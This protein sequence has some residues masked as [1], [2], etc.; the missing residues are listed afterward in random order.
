MAE[1]AL[2]AR[3]PSL[4]E[5]LA[6][7]IVRALMRRDGVTEQGIVTVLSRAKLRLL[8]AGLAPRGARLA[9]PAPGRPGP[10]QWRL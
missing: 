8:D 6:E 7:P 10:E 1:P 4:G 5:I 2:P 9:V 3:M